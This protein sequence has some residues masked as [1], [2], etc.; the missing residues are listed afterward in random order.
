[1]FKKY[2]LF[3][4]LC[5]S[6]W[7]SSYK[8]QLSK[9]Q[10][11]TIAGLIIFGVCSWFIYKKFFHRHREIYL[12]D[13]TKTEKHNLCNL[14]DVLEKL[15]EDNIKLYANNVNRRLFESKFIE[16]HKHY[17]SRS[18]EVMGV[19]YENAFEIIE[20]KFK[21]KLSDQTVKEMICYTAQDGSIGWYNLIDFV[22]ESYGKAFFSKLDSGNNNIFH[23]ICKD[24]IHRQ[25]C[26]S[27]KHIFK[28][29]E[30]KEVFDQENKQGE[31]PLFLIINSILIKNSSE[32]FAQLLV[33]N[34]CDI[35]KK[36]IQQNK[37]P[38][39]LIFEVN[40]GEKQVD[41]LWSVLV[42][43]QKGDENFGMSVY[44]E[45]RK[46]E[47]KQYVKNKFDL[48][49]DSKKNNLIKYSDKIKN[50]RDCLS[51]SY[52]EYKNRKDMYQHSFDDPTYSYII[53]E[54]LFHGVNY[55]ARQLK[56]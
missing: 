7:C 24:Y 6:S 14:Y 3:L 19:A 34:D 49:S 5:N 30:N 1:M 43:P 44:S 8:Y 9:M 36:N 2:L 38:F 15:N 32:F 12:L 39:D 47:Y 54:L 55:I 42:I 53:S 29:I 56:T 10:Q 21:A 31:T 50:V 16:G 26:N 23:L 27:F 51:K 33:K 20:K 40:N 13:L 18:H 17:F 28:S 52:D 4:L 41:V 25:S 48:F 22:F 45:S 35:F 46:E 37:T 11:G